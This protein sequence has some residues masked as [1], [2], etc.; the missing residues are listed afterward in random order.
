[1]EKIS[2][3]T[4]IGDVWKDTVKDFKLLTPKDPLT[5][6]KNRGLKIKHQLL[7]AVLI[8]RKFLRR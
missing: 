4:A 3:E 7:E 6:A 1:M 2:L 5:E 8:A